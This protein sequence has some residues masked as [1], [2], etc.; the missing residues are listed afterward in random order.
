MR[1][2]PAAPLRGGRQPFAVRLRLGKFCLNLR[3]ELQ[4]AA[5]R[6][7]RQHLAGTEFADAR[8]FLHRKR[9]CAEFRAGVHNSG[10]ALCEAQWAQAVAVEA[11]PDKRA[12]AEDHGG[13]PV[14]WLLQV[15]VISV[16]IAHGRLQLGLFFPSHGQQHGEY[17]A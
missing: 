9:D 7:H 4:L 2:W 3:V 16:E 12:V 17:V 1:A 6:V 13:G 14:P 15:G 11:G 5:A 10:A 8:Q